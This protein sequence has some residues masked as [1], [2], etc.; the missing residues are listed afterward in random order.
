[1]KLGGPRVRQE[2]SAAKEMNLNVEY[3]QTDCWASEVSPERSWE[4]ARM[5]RRGLAVTAGP[6]GG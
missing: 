3:S 5:G 2:L 1:M 4:A 6:A